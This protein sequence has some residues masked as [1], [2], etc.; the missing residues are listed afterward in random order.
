VT[1]WDARW[2][3]DQATSASWS[4]PLLVQPGLEDAEA[5]AE[6]ADWDTCVLA[7]LLTVEKLVYCELMLDGRPACSPR[8]TDVLLAAAA[9]SSPAT[10][11]LQR[12]QQ[13]RQVPDPGRATAHAALDCLAAADGYVRGRIPIEV[14][15]MRTPEGFYP[16]LRVAAELE[17]LRKAV[18]LGPFQWNWWANLP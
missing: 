3:A 14:L 7:C 1:G 17:R 16:S 5:A 11:S 13:L 8:E 18:G 2:F 12:I 6:A 10:D 15:P 9:V 4:H